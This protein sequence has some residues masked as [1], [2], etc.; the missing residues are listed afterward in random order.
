[1][2]KLRVQNLALVLVLPTYLS[3]KAYDADIEKRLS[4]MW[5]T[6]RNRVDGGLGSTW[7]SHG[8]HESMD[9][10][11]TRVLHDFH[12]TAAQ[13]LDGGKPD[14]YLD[15]VFNRGH[16]SYDKYPSFLGEMDDHYFYEIDEFERFKKYK[17]LAKHVVG[18]TPVMQREDNDE[19]WE[20]FDVQGESLYSHPPDPN[21]IV[22]DHGLDEDKLWCLPRSMMNQE[23]VINPYRVPY[24]EANHNSHAPQW[25]QKL[26]QPHF[27]QPEKIE[28]FLRHWQHRLG[29]EALK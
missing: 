4:N 28:K 6:H 9:Q 20:Y 5:R 17:P 25:G 27:Y 26:S 7:K 14:A 16:E 2:F 13:L 22:V 21:S 3:K 8:L 1:M 23:L 10:D 19:K 12:W 18:T 11:K 15:N 29:L 24:A